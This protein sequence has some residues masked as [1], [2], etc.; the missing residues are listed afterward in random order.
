MDG[1]QTGLVSPALDEELSR[2]VASLPPAPFAFA[3]GSAVFPQLGKHLQG[4]SRFAPDAD[5]TQI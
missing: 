4:P 3:Y 1:T 2:I 5:A